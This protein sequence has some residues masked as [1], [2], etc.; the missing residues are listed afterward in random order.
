MITRRVIDGSRRGTVYVLV[1]VCAMIV[2]VLGVTGVTIV[3]QE[4]Q[5]AERDLGAFQADLAAVSGLELAM[6]DAQDDAAWRE[7]LHDSAE[8]VSV[9]IDGCSVTVTASDPLDGD[10]ADDPADPV[11]LRAVAQRGTS[12]RMHEVD[13]IPTVAALPALN[14]GLAVGGTL[15]INAA[16]VRASSPVIANGA[17]TITSSSVTADLVSGATI[18]GTSTG[19]RG[20]GQAAFVLPDRA[21]VLAAYQ[22][23]GTTIA[24][25][26]IPSRRIEKQ[27]ITRT[28]NP[29]GSTNASG[30][31]VINCGGNDLEIRDARIVGTLV[32]LN[33]RRLTLTNSV[34]VEDG[35]NGLP[36]LIVDGILDV[37]T[38][39]TEL[40][41]SAQ[42][43][44]FNPTGAAFR[45]V[46]DS[47]Q[48][49]TYPSQI[50]GM[51]VVF[52]NFES[53]TALHAAGPILVSGNATITGGTAMFSNSGLW[54][55]A[56]PAGFTL[57]PTWSYDPA[58]W[59]RAVD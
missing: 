25:G 19:T 1:L 18:S 58:S 5:R 36:V 35:G 30:V 12:R 41:E 16:S 7:K 29:Y 21:V 2:T 45:G 11:R 26:S 15:T 13:V 53:G 24:I 40:S 10:L 59:R 22:A 42:T 55:N 4:R 47:D 3:R 31:Y 14:A 56:P 49:D 46:T 32:V 50:Q 6:T 48:T 52:G 23:M 9:T 20:A 38:A 17:I 51:V 34:L 54:S 37:E 27:T 33:V 39:A 43:T 28:R 44:N 8:A 57:P